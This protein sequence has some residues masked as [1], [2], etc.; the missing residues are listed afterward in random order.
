MLTLR[1]FRK[2]SSSG[3]SMSSARP[4]P[5]LPRAV[6]CIGREMEGGVCGEG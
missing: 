3:S 2:A 1:Y 4:R 6:L 5:D